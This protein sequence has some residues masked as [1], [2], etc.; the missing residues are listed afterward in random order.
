MIHFTYREDDDIQAPRHI[1]DDTRS[2]QYDGNGGRWGDVLTFTHLF[3][4]VFA[5][6]KASSAVAVSTAGHLHSSDMWSTY[7]SHGWSHVFSDFNNLDSGIY[8]HKF[9]HIK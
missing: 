9:Q 5:R 6:V 8:M 2:H 3:I 1:H 7:R 4:L